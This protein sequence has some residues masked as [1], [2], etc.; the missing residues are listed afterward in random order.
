MKVGSLSFTIRQ[1]EPEKKLGQELV[2][3]NKHLNER[4]E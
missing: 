2:K 4:L 3:L 1:S